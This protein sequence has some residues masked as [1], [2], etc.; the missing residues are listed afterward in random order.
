MRSVS[1]V[2][3][4][5][6]KLQ[7]NTKVLCNICE[8]GRQMKKGAYHKAFRGRFRL[9]SVKNVSFLSGSRAFLFEMHLRH[10]WSAFEMHVKR[11]V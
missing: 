2:S 6:L 3:A 4:R 1:I 5:V 8:P 10:G 7:D 9:K 11:C